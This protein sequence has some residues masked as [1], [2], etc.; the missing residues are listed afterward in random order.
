MSYSV[1]FNVYGTPKPKGS[2]RGFPLKNGRFA[3]VETC[4]EL[5]TYMHEVTSEAL[6]HRPEVP[7]NGPV[8]INRTYV[9]LR[10]KAHKK[11]KWHTVKP[12]VDK[13]D[14]ALFDSLKNAGIMQDDAR[15]CAGSHEKLWGETAQ[16]II[17]VE[18]IA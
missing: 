14:R 13:L 7:L 5:P 12:D 16:T 2:K 17:S 8:R 1:T 6:R 3:M 15:V 11:D 9:F 10:N 4:K 18:E